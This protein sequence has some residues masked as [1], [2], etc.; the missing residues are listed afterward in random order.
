MKT[1]VTLFFAVLAA[2]HLILFVSHANAS[3][4]LWIIDL[5]V[6][7]ICLVF[8][9][10]I[11]VKSINRSKPKRKPVKHRYNKLSVQALLK[12]LQDLNEQ[13]RLIERELELRYPETYLTR[14]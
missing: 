3:P 9:A 14:A 7:A 8:T 1:R 10:S 6:T 11:Y 5:L 2:L 4:F 13:E 12:V